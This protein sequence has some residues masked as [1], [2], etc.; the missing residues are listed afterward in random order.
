MFKKN[1]IVII[2]LFLLFGCADYS[3]KVNEVI[4]KT[5]PEKIK[6]YAPDYGLTL[7]KKRSSTAAR[8]GDRAS[9]H[10]KKY[11]KKAKLIFVN[12]G[13]NYYEEYECSN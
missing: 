11:N 12:F 7:Q 6:I 13:D 9:R 4:D 8:F 10:C 2:F 1:F 3:G 5:F